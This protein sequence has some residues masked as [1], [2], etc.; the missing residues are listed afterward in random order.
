MDPLGREKLHNFFK[1]PLQK[2]KDLLVSDTEYT[3][4]DAPAVL[5]LHLWGI[6]AGEIRVG[7]KGSN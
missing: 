6:W 2:L 3:M 4:K 1:N 5:N 7:G